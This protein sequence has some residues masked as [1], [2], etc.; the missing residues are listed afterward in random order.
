M[1]F[2]CLDLHKSLLRVKDIKQKGYLNGIENDRINATTDLYRIE[3]ILSERGKGK[4][5]M[6][7]KAIGQ[8]LACLLTI[9]LIATMGF[10]F[11]PA[12]MGEGDVYAAAP[13]Y[14]LPAQPATVSPDSEEILPGVYTVTA[15]VGASKDTA[16][17][18]IPSVAKQ[19]LENIH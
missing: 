17:I 14:T 8:K 19:N 2:L 13:E 18:G 4:R 5:K 12:L 1:F 9:A 15:E 10:T 3:Q 11:T 16:T 7:S 6:I